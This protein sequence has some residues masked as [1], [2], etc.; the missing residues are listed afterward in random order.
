M[1][2]DY[3]DIT[4]RLGPPLWHDSRGVPRYEPFTPHM[5]TVYDD[6]VTLMEIEC[7]C[8]RAKMVVASTASQLIAKFRSPTG[9]KLRSPTQREVILPSATPSDPWVC[10][11]D[12]HYGDPPRH[13]FEDG[14]ACVAGPTMNS[15]PIRVIE[16]WGRH[17]E[18]GTGRWTRD[19]QYEIAMPPL[20]DE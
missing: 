1:H 9:A 16:F 6:Y 12:F 3:D 4:K 14:R 19:P 13:H 8:C 17:H 2:I 11:G 15:I 20:K 10:I 7:Q 5:A 18:S